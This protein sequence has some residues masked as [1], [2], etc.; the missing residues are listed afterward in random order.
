MVQPVHAEGAVSGGHCRCVW[1]YV[2]AKQ[3]HGA[4]TSGSALIAAKLM[5]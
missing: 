5:I 1:R 2:A 4:S 3:R